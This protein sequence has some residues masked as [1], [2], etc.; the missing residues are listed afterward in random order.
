M[1]LNKLVLVALAASALH[2]VMADKPLPSRLHGYVGG[3]YKVLLADISGDRK[4]DL[5]LAY[6]QLG[7]VS[8]DRL[9]EDGQLIPLAVNHFSDHNRTLNPD[10]ASWSVPHVHNLAAGDLDGD[11]LVDLAFCVGGA[12]ISK[13][14]RV[15]LARNAGK[16]RLE[17]TVEYLVPSE[18]K[19][20]R[21]AD[22][23][24][25]GTLDLLYTAR[26]SGYTG[27][28]SVGRLYIRAGMGDFKFGHATES[29]AGKSAYY[30]ET[31][32]LNN[33]G[34]PDILV[35]NEHDSC[36]TFFINPGKQVFSANKSLAPQIL[37]V[38]QI[39]GK[40]SHA[41]NDVRA[42]DINGDGNQDVITANLGT[43]TVGIFLGTGEGSF[44]PGRLIEA[45][46]NGAFLATGDLDADGD[47]DFVI[48]HWTEDFASVFLNNGDGSFA[49][50]R[51]YETGSGNYGV[52]VA[53][54]DGDGQLD[55]VTANYRHKSASLL[56]GNGDG[57]FKAAATVARG[58]RCNQGQWYSY[59]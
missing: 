14:G 17:R 47:V 37:R 23:D 5:V 20:I 58:L 32:D 43:S 28:L 12:G 2:P 34:H 36:V 6:H 11:G 40:R 21:L 22:L 16:G 53:D 24:Q 3:P 49:A 46:T 29:P 59:P 7:I 54:L 35:P 31:A 42:A 56:M 4:L 1:R 33:D 25:D 10:D 44:S 52:D 9:G 27:D 30:V 38:P 55:I 41:V 18:A 15:V 48:T 51:D 39:P 45:G 8:I 19:G 26:G 57:T 13:P 50:R